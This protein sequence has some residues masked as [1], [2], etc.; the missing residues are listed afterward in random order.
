MR[1]RLL[2]V[3]GL[4]VLG[5]GPRTAQAEPVGDAPAGF[6]SV[7]GR[8]LSS[9]R[10]SGASSIPAAELE[11]WTG[12]R[13]GAVLDR[14]RWEVLADG[15]ARAAS[16]RGY[17]DA[18]VGRVAFEEDGDRLR[19]DVSIEA[20]SPYRLGKVVLAGLPV[21]DSASA[22]RWLGLSSG[23]PWSEDRLS[24]GLARLVES[25][26]ARGRPFAQARVRRLHVAEGTADVEIAVAEGDSARVDSVRLDGPSRTRP[27]ILR[28]ALTG[29][30][31]APYDPRRAAEARTRLLHLGTFTSVG[32]PRFEMTAPGRGLLRY[33]VAEGGS[34]SFEGV[35][36]YQGEG[37][38]VAGTARLTLDNIAG[39]ARRAQLSWQGRGSGNADFRFAY[40]E[41]FVLGLPV[42]AGL[43]FAQELADSLYT[44]TEYGASADMAVGEGLALELG[45]GG[46]RVVTETGDVR[47]SNRQRTWVG[48]RRESEGWRTAGESGRRRALRVEVTTTQEFL[49]DHL[50][51]GTEARDRVTELTAGAAM[52]AP[53]DGRL[54]RARFSG[55]LRLGAS[56]ELGV[57]D[58]FPLG[59]AESLRGYR[60]RQFRAS[61]FGLLR[62]EH[63]WRLGDG[64][65]FLFAD[66]ALFGREAISDSTGGTKTRY[67][68]GYG[69]GAWLP[70]AV[71]RAGLSLG[72][73]RGD[74]PRDAKVH[75]TLQSRF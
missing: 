17:L 37:G 30:A 74:G 28:R 54:V 34:S 35:L 41:P 72:W 7:A 57:Y 70:T 64:D 68:A 1:A 14:A 8:T 47:R 44:R 60:E 31:G 20:G 49:H 58:L 22:A 46:A 63:G 45:V 43:S 71:G 23:D 56:R 12:W 33:P 39:T 52:A 9:V 62:L 16:A 61:R 21:A 5:P 27:A 36:G 19:A 38:S 67:R 73:G 50:V 13:A 29:L 69:F 53:W 2:F 11:G 48:L 4:L 42:A 15:V 3:L 51:D 18:R 65:V 66:Q 59:G 25:L 6:S 40:R 32:E 26:S 55:G 24:A 75:L 10:W